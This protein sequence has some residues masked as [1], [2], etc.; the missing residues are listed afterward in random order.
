MAYDG[1]Q[2]GKACLACSQSIDKPKPGIWRL[3]KPSRSEAFA[4][5]VCDQFAAHLLLHSVVDARLGQGVE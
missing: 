1:Q 3:W 4:V 5:A 2:R